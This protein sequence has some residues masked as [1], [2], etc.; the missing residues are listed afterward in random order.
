MRQLLLVM[1]HSGD[2][3]A[4]RWSRTPAHYWRLSNQTYERRAYTLLL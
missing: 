3:T 4:Q 2:V 1:I